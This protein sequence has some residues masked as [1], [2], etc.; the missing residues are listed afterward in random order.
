MRNTSLL[1]RNK[2]TLSAENGRGEGFDLGL[3]LII[4]L[5][6]VFMLTHLEQLI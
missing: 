5:L 6:V 1:G 2:S 3:N 4:K